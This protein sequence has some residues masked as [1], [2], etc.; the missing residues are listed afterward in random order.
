MV[1][2]I[3]EDDRWLFAAGRHQGMHEILGCHLD[4]S[5]A[6]FRLWAPGA[7][8]ASVVGTF[9]NW[10][11]NAHPLSSLGNGFWGTRVEGVQ[12]GD[13]YKF[14]VTT[15]RYRSIDKADPFSVLMEG[16]P[17]TAS[18]AWDLAY[19]WDDSQWMGE[20][21]GRLANDQPVSI[22]EV[23]LGSWR[24]HGQVSY[25]KIAKPLADYALEQGFT[26]VEFLPLMEHPFYGSWGYQITGFFAPTARYGTPQDL[27]YLIDH[28]HQRGIGVILDW[29]PSHF[30]ADQHG[31]AF[32]DGTH[33]YEHPDPRRGF[34]PDW[35]SIIF[36]YDRGEV[37]SFLLSSA[38]SWLDRYHADGLRVDAVASMLYLDYS[39]QPGQWL[40]NETGGREH[41]GAIELFRQL[42]GS[43]RHSHPGVAMLAEESTSWP[44]VTGPPEQDSLGFHYK[45]DMGW[46]NDTL[47]FVRLDP[48]FRSHPDSHRLLTFRGLYA[49]SEDFLLPLSHDE[50]VYGKRSLF[51]K[52]WGNADQK[53]AGLRTLLGYMW[54]VPGKKLL[55]MGGE[56]GQIREW[57]HDSSLDWDL[58]DEPRHGHILDWVR[59]LNRQ[60]RS[61]P[62]LY[63]EDAIS[64]GFEWLEADDYPRS[65]FAYLRRAKGDRPVLVILN[66]TPVTWNR[67]HVGVPPSGDWKIT[68]SSDDGRFG[69]YNS[70]PSASIASTGRPHQDQ[71]DSLMLNLPPLSATFLV[72]VN[73]EPPT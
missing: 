37:R 51:D 50:V 6:T 68:L 67:Y 57:N 21:A 7:A 61:E 3:T 56:F 49:Y 20:R 19:E 17:A 23:H 10:K 32:F 15:A 13:A 52:Q 41:L 55:F 65:V 69:G 44:N 39:R 64:S 35:N 33:L 30:P 14:Q 70:V 34:H 5:G 12:H 28:L 46:M 62:A 53:A 66:F 8:W 71:P 11:G 38:Y 54:T 73:D 58:L 59:A 24:D 18:R 9:N 72:P 26:H 40:P 1:R 60:L 4:D 45:W 29:V 2:E 31:L 36:N 42:N 25:R 22:Y 16:P 47:R 63:R 27:M 48:L 43:V